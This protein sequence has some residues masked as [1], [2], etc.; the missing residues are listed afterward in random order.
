MIIQK[1]NLNYV[2]QIGKIIDLSP[3]EPFKS[4]S[5]MYVL[6]L[7][8]KQPSNHYAKMASI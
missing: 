8:L 2:V 3:Y 6:D 1:M 4:Y 5:Y 7:D